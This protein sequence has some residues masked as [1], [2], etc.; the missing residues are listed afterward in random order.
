[1]KIYIWLNRNLAEVPKIPIVTVIP[2]MP[3]TYLRVN[4]VARVNEII[5]FLVG[6]IW[7]KAQSSQNN[8]NTQES[9]ALT[10]L[11]NILLNSQNDLIVE[12]LSSSAD[13]GQASQARIDI[14]FR[15]FITRY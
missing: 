6:D 11:S 12:Y 14:A 7:N 3:F 10:E 9:A 4:E 15:A 13:F 1:M 5:T 2:R 8:L